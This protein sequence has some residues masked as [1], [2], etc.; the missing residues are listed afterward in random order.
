M[1]TDPNEI[2]DKSKLLW[3]NDLHKDKVVSSHCK[4]L[5]DVFSKTWNESLQGSLLEIGCGSGSDLK[6]FSSMKGLNH[7]TA[8]DI[9]SNV[10]HLAKQY[11]DRKDII[12]KRGNA[13]SLDFDDNTF[14][15]IYSFGIFHHTADPI[16][17]ISEARRVLKVGGK[18]F[19]YL[20]SSHEDMI[21]KRWGVLIEQI[22]MKFFKYLP[23]KLQN[24]ICIVLSPICWALFSIPSA[25]LRLL[26]FSILANK[27]PFFFG[28]HPFSL[29][30]DLKDRL[31]A[32]VNHRFTKL[33]ISKIL[34]S[35]QFENQNVIK[36][37]TG[38]YICAKK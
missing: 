26:G 11:E 12:V 23:Y 32:P 36:T 31:M 10:T 7:I 13:L 25:L 24:I 9:G 28:R 1:L 34:S 38:L 6:F 21:F 37:A 14:D 22:I 35:L 4:Q 19:L 17:C 20:Y 16:L 18:V 27:I 29:I 5:A 33:E 3:G 2:E 15:V 30:G 8:I